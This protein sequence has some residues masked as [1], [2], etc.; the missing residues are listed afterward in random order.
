MKIAF[1]T[2]TYLPQINGVATSID[3]F[4]HDLERLGHTV[5]I[6]CPKTR[7]A[8]KSTENI[9]RLPA[10][11]YPF[12]K[13]YGMG[14]PFSRRL[15]HFKKEQFDII[16]I[17][18]P[19]FVGHLGQYLGWKHKIPRVHTSHTFWSKYLHYMPLLPKKL[20]RQADEVLLTRKFCNR[21]KHV[22]APSSVMKDW[23]LKNDVRVPISVIPTGVQNHEIPSQEKCDDF[24][25]RLGIPSNVPML[26]FSGIL[27][28]KKTVFFLLKVFKEVL[29]DVPNAALFIASNGPEWENMKL[30]AKEEGLDASIVMPGYLDHNDL[31]FAYSSADV[32]LFPPKTEMQG[33]GLLESLSCGCPAVCINEM[34]VRDLL[35]KDQKGGFLVDDNLEE[36][37]SH[38]KKLIQDSKLREQKSAEAIERALDFSSVKMAKKLVTVYENVIQK[39]G[40]N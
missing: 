31:F 34:G 19:F 35:G 33:L 3:T 8:K 13:E 10:I 17:H 38:V 21:N 28:Q 7:F 15:R 24:K 5:K 4:K 26:L 1:F 22:I 36:F 32:L 12:Q 30:I 14:I 9:I 2:C 11:P 25:L 37:A 16:H 20:G 18:T 40:E 23:L 39:T 6:Y 27:G 29:K